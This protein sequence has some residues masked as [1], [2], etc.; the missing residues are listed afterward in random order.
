MTDDKPTH[1][2]AVAGSELTAASEM[3]AD[4]NGV[5]APSR[6]GGSSRFLTDVIVDLG[7]AGADKVQDAVSHARTSGT[8]PEQTLLSNGTITQEGLARALAERYGLD[9]LDLT[10]CNVD[11]AALNLI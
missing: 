4:W 2:R 8:T 10:V 7:L 6:R 11:M 5:I 9:Y 1:L 3:P